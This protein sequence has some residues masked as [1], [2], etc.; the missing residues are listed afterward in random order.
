MCPKNSKY[1][2]Y[3]LLYVLKFTLLSTRFWRTSK[4]DIG[5]S[6]VIFF[7]NI[8]LYCSLLY[9]ESLKIRLKIAIS[10]RYHTIKFTNNV[11][12][13]CNY[14]LKFMFVH[15][16]N[17]NPLGTPMFGQLYDPVWNQKNR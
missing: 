4:T 17:H 12:V 14:L 13:N 3:F 16:C 9:K 7:K 6:L 11:H 8:S 2:S 5:V 10:S 1:N 15:W